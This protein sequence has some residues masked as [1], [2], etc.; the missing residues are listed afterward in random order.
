M[1]CHFHLLHLD[2]PCCLCLL[3]PCHL[4]LLICCLHLLTQS[5]SRTCSNCLPHTL[6]L[7]IRHTMYMSHLSHHQRDVAGL[8][9]LMM[10]TL[11]V[12]MSFQSSPLLLRFFHQHPS[13][14]LSC[15]HNCNCN[16]NHNHNHQLLPPRSGNILLKVINYP[17]LRRALGNDRGRGEE[18][19]L[20]TRSA[21]AS[22]HS[23]LNSAL[24]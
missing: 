13:L 6:L 17:H 15:E 22:I 9:Y 14:A 5:I 21:G 24:S 16:H 8:C 12:A 4:H 3:P 1:G 11:T 2:P 20:S 7:V 19:P 18:L 10:L 23:M